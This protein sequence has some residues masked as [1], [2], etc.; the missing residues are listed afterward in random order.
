MAGILKRFRDIM[1]ANINALLDKAEDPEK[2]IDQYLRDMESDLGKVKAETASVMADAEKAKRDLAEADEE[3]AKMQVYAEKALVAGNEE[4][5]RLFLAK[6]A[7]LTKDRELKQ[8]IADATAANA[9]KMRQMHDKLTSDIAA[10]N[11]RKARIKAKVQAAKAQEHINE[12]N[13]M[14]G[15]IDITDGMSAFDK[16][17]EKADH[18][19]DMA[20]AHAELNGS[21]EAAAPPVADAA[22]KYEDNPE[23]DAELA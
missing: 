18:M 5:A 13:D 1:A 2:M 15:S 22:Q 10:L 11:E 17:E 19:L 14:I 8:Q 12:L 20:N 6:K 9:Q 21:A 23:I 4:D 16:M 3:I 7:E